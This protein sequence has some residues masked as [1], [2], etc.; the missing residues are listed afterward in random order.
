MLRVSA[1]SRDPRDLPNFDD[2]NVSAADDD[3]PFA[4]LNEEQDLS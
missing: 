2:V 4:L 3:E 1:L